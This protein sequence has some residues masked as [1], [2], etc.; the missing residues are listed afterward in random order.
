MPLPRGPVQSI[1][2]V[3][4][5][6][7][8]GSVLET[9][10]TARYRLDAARRHLVL[11]ISIADRLRITY[12]AGNATAESLPASVRQGLLVHVAA[13]Y[14]GDAHGLPERAGHLYAPYR[15]RSL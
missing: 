8:T 12:R 13:L 4:R 3:E 1:L 5:L 2:S 7:A 9:L 14:E 11:N 15:E 10:P 6:S